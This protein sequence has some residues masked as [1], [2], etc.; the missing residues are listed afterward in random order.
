V[1]DKVSA[2]ASRRLD[3]PQHLKRGDQTES[4][5]ADSGLGALH[6]LASML[7]GATPAM[8][9]GKSILDIGCGNQ[10]PEALF[11][12]E[13][14]L[15]KYVG[16]DVDGALIAVLREQADDPRFEFV[17]FDVFNPRHNPRSE[18]PLHAKTALPIQPQT[19]DY[20]LAFGVTRVL[21]PEDLQAYVDILGQY[22]HADTRLV[23]DGL[24][25]S[26]IAK[27]RLKEPGRPLSSSIFAPAYVQRLLHGGG[28]MVERALFSKA[29]LFSQVKAWPV[30]DVGASKPAI[31]A[32]RRVGASADAPPAFG[33]SPWAG[34]VSELTRL[35]SAPD[36]W[37]QVYERLVAAAR[38]GA[39][40]GLGDALCEGLAD[41]P[42]GDALCAFTELA[43]A[44]L[45]MRR[46]GRSAALH[47][48]FV[49]FR[50]CFRDDASYRAAYDSLP[51]EVRS[52]IALR[53]WRRAAEL[54]REGADSPSLAPPRAGETGGARPLLVLAPGDAGAQGCLLD[55]AD[56]PNVELVLLERSPVRRLEANGAQHRVLNLLDHASAGGGE[57]SR[58]SIDAARAI[59]E[60]ILRQV[61][62]VAGDPL[63]EDDAGLS[64]IL[65]P[66]VGSG[67]VGVIEGVASLVAAIRS[68]AYGEVALVC[69]WTASG[70]AENVL[71]LLRDLGLDPLLYFPDQ[72]AEGRRS[73]VQRL[74]LG[75]FGAPDPVVK[76][77][78][79]EDAVAAARRLALG[80]RLAP[81]FGKASED[82]T[83]WRSFRGRKPGRGKP[84]VV[85]LLST[86]AMERWLDA[87]ELVT[88][89][90]ADHKLVLLVSD[91][92]QGRAE[93]QIKALVAGQ[94][95]DLDAYWVDPALAA[96]EAAAQARG[97]HRL[98]RFVFET[99]RT[100]G[101]LTIDGLAVGHLLRSW[102][103]LI[104]TSFLARMLLHGRLY[105]RLLESYD[106][107]AVVAA[108]SSPADAAAILE[109]ARGRG[110]PAM[111]IRTVQTRSEAG[112]AA[113]M[114]SRCYLLHVNPPSVAGQGGCEIEVH[115]GQGPASRFLLPRAAREGQVYEADEVRKDLG[116]KLGDKLVLFAPATG[117]AA[118]SGLEG[119]LD[120][121]DQRSRVRMLVMPP[122]D[123][124][125][126]SLAR[127][128]DA[129][130]ARELQSRGK[131]IRDYSLYR[132]LAGADLVVTAR[133]A[134][135]LEASAA[136]LPVVFL[137]GPGASASADL[138]AREIADVASGPGEL[139]SLV[140]AM[141]DNRPARRAQQ[142]RRETFFRVRPQLKDAE[143]T[144]L[145]GAAAADLGAESRPTPPA[146]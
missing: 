35:V 16:V 43:V 136:G 78:P 69:E 73:Y 1:L 137:E 30:Q 114:A 51:G 133:G 52:S 19:F 95:V 74:A 120:V 21:S 65:A 117:A 64:T 10:L 128:A 127:Y 49:R 90:G 113:R 37:R 31:V 92:K 42:G 145:V 108:T 67:L 116:C 38:H 29:S 41:V 9:E 141:L 89:L 146:G 96:E 86:G 85:L 15:S 60:G 80:D 103:D 66:A 40:Q 47:E 99:L 115:D 11:R 18:T 123:E 76:A 112:L 54:G 68:G 24:F 139:T 12:Y 106:P 3:I 121:L 84:A 7:G 2:P 118:T 110:A 4:D 58:R 22:A 142:E 57:A 50:R 131:V 32:R 135:A 28:W 34:E 144:A 119:L 94:P 46:G 140:L 126:D 13:V 75:R 81:D 105:S 111:Q 83:L 44:L 100:D 71:A 82:S 77:R 102:W 143:L 132:A 79:S 138:A 5:A 130:Q 45:D 87:R 104:F 56:D 122:P 124:R 61:Y 14:G 109:Y 125:L 129:V 88:L 26:D 70:V 17:H 25:D 59:G 62:E 91:V 55:M 27:F 97:L 101:Q 53:G 8:F 134:V 63:P 39:H 48:A 98:S 23:F 20:I 36:I 107:R 72:P 93:A 33:A 6:T